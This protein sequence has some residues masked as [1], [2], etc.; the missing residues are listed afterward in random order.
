MAAGLK[1]QQKRDGTLQLDGTIL[2]PILAELSFKIH[3]LTEQISGKQ[4]RLHKIV[5]KPEASF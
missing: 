3:I 1:G 2:W 5:T 4:Y